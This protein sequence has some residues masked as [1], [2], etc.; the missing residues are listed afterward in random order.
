MQ[1]RGSVM[2]WICR[3]CLERKSASPYKSTEKSSYREP[4]RK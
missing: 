3:P 4:M 1:R 2:R